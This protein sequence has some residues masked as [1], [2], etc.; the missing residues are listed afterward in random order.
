[1]ISLYKKIK[2][3]IIWSL[4][5]RR[6][7]L[8]RKKSLDGLNEWRKYSKKLSESNK[9]NWSRFCEDLNDLICNFISESDF[10][11]KYEHLAWEKN[12][13]VIQ[14]GKI[15]NN[16][17]PSIKSLMQIAFNLGSALYYL[18]IGDRQMEEI[19]RKINLRSLNNPFNFINI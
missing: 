19:N 12:H 16:K 13:F 9:F 4:F 18:D 17:V 15:P 2:I 3:K 8:T 7:Y 10:D 11:K 1:M 6:G 14:L 5:L